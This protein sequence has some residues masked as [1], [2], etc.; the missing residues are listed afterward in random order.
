M[1]CEE[2][3]VHVEGVARHDEREDDDEQH[4][5]EHEYEGKMSEN[6]MNK[7][8]HVQS[9]YTHMTACAVLAITGNQ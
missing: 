4:D 5:D 7:V 2:I 6:A 1:H 3:V 8:K 9:Q